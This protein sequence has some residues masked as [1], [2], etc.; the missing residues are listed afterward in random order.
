MYCR[1]ILEHS[2]AS[3]LI[4]LHHIKY[5]ISNLGLDFNKLWFKM[6]TDKWLISIDKKN[7][8]DF[9]HEWMKK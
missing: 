3:Y 4:I 2:N 1:I 6:T 5:N 7:E 8:W 9:S